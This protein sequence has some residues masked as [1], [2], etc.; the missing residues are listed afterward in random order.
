[1]GTWASA[2]GLHAGRSGAGCPGYGPDVRG[3]MGRRMSGAGARMSGWGR[4]RLGCSLDRGAGFPGAGPDVRAVP[5]RM[6]GPWS[7]LLLLPAVLFI[8]ELGGLSVFMCIF[9]RVLLTPD[10]A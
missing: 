1:M 5:G 3:F 2:Q 6:S 10:H 7:Y 8:R 9:V 4:T